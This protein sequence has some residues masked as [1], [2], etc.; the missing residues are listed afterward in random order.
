MASPAWHGRQHSGTAR[1]FR[2]QPETEVFEAVEDV[3]VRWLSAGKQEKE[4]NEEKPAPVDIASATLRVDREKAEFRGKV[5]A[6]GPRWEMDA[7]EVD[8]GLGTN[9]TV[10]AIL[11]RG[12]VR[13]L[14]EMLAVA[15]S[16]NGPSRTMQRVLRGG[17]GVES[18]RWE[19]KA[20]ELR[21]SI[22][23]QGEGVSHLDASGGRDGAS[24]GGPGPWR[25]AGIRGG[26]RAVAVDGQRGAPG[27]GRPST[28]WDCR[29]RC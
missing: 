19:I 29:R 24:S 23:D 22:D 20:R 27:G 21:A 10:R 16:T 4:D 25:T 3:R 28:S 12:D 14:Y 13:F 1:H 5:H 8:F 17:E 6:T 2:I 26:G 9:R 15:P 18:R 7:G 11:A